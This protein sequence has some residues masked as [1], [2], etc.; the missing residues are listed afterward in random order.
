MCDLLAQACVQNL[1]AF[2]C[3]YMR[4]LPSCACAPPIACSGA[5][6]CFL[7]AAS[8]IS[9]PSIA[10]GQGRRLTNMWVCDGLGKGWKRL[11]EDSG[12]ARQ[13]FDKVNM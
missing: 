7:G 10:E 13:A 9:S 2:A 1:H 12:G 11:T 8:A 6:C 4:T 5:T 3:L